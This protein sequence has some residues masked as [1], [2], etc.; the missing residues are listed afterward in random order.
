MDIVLAS[1]SPRRREL[2][3]RVAPEFEVCAADV[4]ESSIGDNDPVLFAVNAAV[5]K[6]RA[7]ADSRPEALVIG[8]D[9]VVAV[10]GRILGKPR[11]R[12]EA[13]AMLGLLSGRKHR[14]VSGVALYK[15]DEDKLLT[16]YEISHVTFRRLTEEM[17]EE[18]LDRNDYVDK[19]GSY[20]VQ[21][22]GNAFVASL[23]GDYDNVVGF[24]VKR[25]RRLLERFRAPDVEALVEDV[26]LPNDWGVARAGGRI[27][28][29]P[30]AVPGDRLRLRVIKD[31]SRYGYAETVKV[32]EPSSHRAEPECP[33][34]GECGG[35]MLQNLL[36]EKQLEIKERYLYETLKRIGGIAPEEDVR[37]AIAPSPELY[38]YRNKMEF[39]FGFE[40]GKAILGLRERSSPFGP[41]RWRT[42]P[43]ERCAIFSPAA[44]ALFPVF[45]EFAREGGFSVF[46]RRTGRGFLRNAVLREGKRTGEVMAV[47]V[48]TGEG[49]PD[50]SDFARRATAVF[51]RLRSVYWGVNNAPSDVVQYEELT[52]LAGEAFIE[53]KI[54]DLT[55]RVYPQTFFQPNPAA[56]EALYK[57]IVMETGISPA[58]R[59]LGLYCGAGT[60]EI[61]LSRRA[62]E[63]TG[64][65]S[66]A[67]NIAAAEENR[68]L[69]GAQNSRFLEGTVEKLLANPPDAPPDILVLDPPRSGLSDKAMRRVLALG[70]PA[71]VYV[72]CGPSTLARDLKI[73]V[74]NGY[75]LERVAPYDFF[76]HTAHLETLAVLRR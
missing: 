53:E 28:F 7:A 10:A 51:P 14:V 48:T 31:M 21:D 4:D 50:L 20:A 6:A 76:P 23:A 69:N 22:V 8:A 49:E 47:L 29:V 27:L 46:E 11:D 75:R 66:V 58:H 12:E 3:A 43:L 34:F 35:C 39:S 57:R 41:K 44:A 19:A 65:D 45:L 64:L 71:V 24:P 70:A 42:T 5:L 17:I 37:S 16:G 36:Y 38:H 61:F 55:F 60:M 9:T 25:V 2:M 72:S 62:G 56:A 59:V 13:R 73:L 68:A 18:Y 33:H 67:A 52:L 30:G 1:R 15:K 40:E 63:V 74:E 54:E 26:A 32:L